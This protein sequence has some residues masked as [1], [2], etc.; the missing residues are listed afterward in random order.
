M[1]QFFV[2]IFEMLCGSGGGIL[3]LR[4]R[5]LCSDYLHIKFFL[6]VRGTFKDIHPH[7]F[8]FYIKFLNEKL[9]PIDNDL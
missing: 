1:V 5:N 9:Y 8:L 7:I 3:E 2:V 4:Q 6:C